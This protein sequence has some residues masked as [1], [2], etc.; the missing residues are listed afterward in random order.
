M[1]PEKVHLKKLPGGYFIMKYYQ[2][3]EKCVL[4]MGK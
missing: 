1:Y 3:V 4:K 2:Q